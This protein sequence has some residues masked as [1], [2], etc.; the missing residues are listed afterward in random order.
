MPHQKHPPLARPPL[1]YYSR[2]E[3]A[4]VG[5]D[6]QLAADTAERWIERL[7]DRYRG[8][9][10]RGK[11]KT[12]D[13]GNL[14]KSGPKLFATPR[15]EWNEF[16]DRL[17]GQAFDV[18]FTNGNHYPAARQIVF[19]NPD[20]YG[21]LERRRHQLTEVIAVVHYPQ[22]GQRIPPWLNEQLAAQAA[23]GGP[24]PL[25]CRLGELDDLVLPRIEQLLAAARPPL[26]AV[27]LA[28]G[29]SRRMGRDK[30]TLEYHPGRG[31]ATRMAELTRAAGLPTY[32][33]LRDA[34]HRPPGTD[35]IPVLTDRLLGAGPLGAI[36]TAFLHDPAAA[37]L[38]LA[39]DLP[40]F[41][42]ATLEQLLAARDPRRYA[43]AARRAGE[44]FPEPLVAIYEPRAYQRLLGFLSLGYGCPRK[45]LINSPVA[46]LDLDDATPLT[47]VNTPEQR[48]AAL[49]RLGA[50]ASPR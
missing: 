9:L 42:A 34:A 45:L 32:L 3:F 14:M 15:A 18:T 31:E 2:T 1:G 13:D 16:D 7:A 33:S 26:R 50:A 30:S 11:Y 21:T 19:L 17:Y 12:E 49:D 35:D 41:D 46:T 39:C 43:T 36:V 10:L 22:T 23:A 27:V 28:G 37:W 29:E 48:R 47:N 24:A 4:L 8:Q 44:P 40:H 38:V 20:K 6:C 25:V 5:G